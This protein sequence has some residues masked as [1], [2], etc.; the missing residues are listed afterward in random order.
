MS[1]HSGTVLIRDQLSKATDET[2]NSLKTKRNDTG[3]LL[4]VQSVVLEQ[5]LAD[6]EMQ[7]VVVMEVSIYQTE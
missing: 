7:E 3:N 4:N 5:L 2:D 6:P 1:N